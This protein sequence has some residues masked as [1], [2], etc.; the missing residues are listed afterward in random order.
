MIGDAILDVSAHNVRK[1]EDTAKI[2]TGG[3]GPKELHSGVTMPDVDI[4][5]M[6]LGVNLHLREHWRQGARVAGIVTR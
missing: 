1:G 3:M 2:T 4:S 6:A 5:M